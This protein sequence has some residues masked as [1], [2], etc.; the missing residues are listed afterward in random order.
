MWRRFAISRTWT[1]RPLFQLRP[2]HRRFNRDDL[3]ALGS[4]LF[5]GPGLFLLLGTTT[6]ASLVVFF[7]H[8]MQVQSWLARRLALHLSHATGCEIAFGGDIVPDWR[9]GTLVFQ[10]LR[11]GRQREG[12]ARIDLAV[13]RVEL[14]LS[15]ARWLEGRGLVRTLRISGVRGSVDSR[16]V[17]Y[18]PEWRYPAD[19]PGDLDLEEVSVEDVVLTVND[20][21]PLSIL[22]ASIPRLRLGWLLLDLLR[23]EQAVGLYDGALFSWHR[24]LDGG[25]NERELRMDGLKAGHVV[26]G[27]PGVLGHIHRG[28]VDVLARLVETDDVIDTRVRLLF[29]NIRLR[30]DGEMSLATRSLLGY[31]NDH[32]PYIPLEAGLGLRTAELRGTWTLR[33]SGIM[34]GLQAHLSAALYR[35]MADRER[36]LQRVRKVG[37]WSAYRLYRQLWADETDLVVTDS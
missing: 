37:I 30:T 5:V 10:G 19:R 22:T 35:M 31:L 25:P 16:P 6:C 11:L 18:D 28:T 9:R 23:T 33:E 29:R 7:A 26:G 13:E 21:F 34:D 8:G 14:M 32:R 3:L 36:R 2:R 12:W 20:S 24:P 17:V 15:F 27:L 4:W 1:R